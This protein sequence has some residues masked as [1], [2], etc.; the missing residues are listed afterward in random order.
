MLPSLIA[1]S[2]FGNLLSSSIGQARIIREIA[3]QGVGDSFWYQTLP[4]LTALV[5]VGDPVLLVLQ[6]YEAIRNAC[7]SP[8]TQVHVRTVFRPH[9]S[10]HLYLFVKISTRVPFTD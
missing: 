9:P 1:I 5:H 6:Q 8:T 7:G 10:P 2:A 4:V 3:R